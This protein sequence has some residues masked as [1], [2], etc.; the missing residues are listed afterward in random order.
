MSTTY[1][2]DENQHVSLC[3]AIDRILNKGA[4]IVGEATI[5]VANVDLIYLALQI[6][7][8]SIETAGHFKKDACPAFHWEAGTERT[9][10]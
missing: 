9:H 4:V 5:S 1:A 3:E 2:F 10:K 8:S 6:M 7:L